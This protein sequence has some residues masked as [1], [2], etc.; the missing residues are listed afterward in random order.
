MS[1]SC[2]GPEVGFWEV[3]LRSLPPLDRH[4]C[5]SSVKEKHGC[6]GALGRARIFGNAEPLS[7]HFASRRWSLLSQNQTSIH[8]LGPEGRH[9]RLSVCSLPVPKQSEGSLREFHLR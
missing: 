8:C 1:G 3:H 5:K 9:R 2:S 4:P 6:P 7:S